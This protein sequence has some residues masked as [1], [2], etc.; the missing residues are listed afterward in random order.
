MMTKVKILINSLDELLSTLK[1][2]NSVALTSVMKLCC[3]NVSE[4]TK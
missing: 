1:L 3:I 2:S 4:Y